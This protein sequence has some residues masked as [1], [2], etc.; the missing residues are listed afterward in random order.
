MSTGHFFATPGPH[1]IVKTKLVT[2]YFRAWSTIMLGK[3]R[4]PNGP[5]AYVD[6]FSG[7]GCFDDGKP[8]TP[9][10]IRGQRSRPLSAAGDDIQ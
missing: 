2:K 7:P 8:S 10:W 4:T 9:L 1:N 3:S 6:L 5:L